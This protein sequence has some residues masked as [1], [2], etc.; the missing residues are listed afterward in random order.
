MT[1]SAATWTLAGLLAHDS[2]TPWTLTGLL[3]QI[4]TGILA[5]ATPW[6]LTGLLSHDSATPWTI[7]GLLAH[8]SATP[9]PFQ[10]YWPLIA[11][12]SPWTHCLISG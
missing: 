1:V 3:A 4:R 9:R 2:A 6:T 5:S 8:N 11:S 10:G 7:T 12:A